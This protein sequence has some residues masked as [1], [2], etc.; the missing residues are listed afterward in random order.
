MLNSARW[1]QNSSLFRYPREYVCIELDIEQSLF[2][3]RDSRGKRTSKQASASLAAF[4]GWAT[5]MMVVTLAARQAR[6]V[7]TWQTIFALACLFV[8][9]DYP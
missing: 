4:A 7:S 5:G 1:R 2:P 8:S 3:L 6:H 9:L